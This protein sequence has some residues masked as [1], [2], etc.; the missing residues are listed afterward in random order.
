MVSTG[1]QQQ[2]Q[3]MWDPVLYDTPARGSS[4]GPGLNAPLELKNLEVLKEW[5]DEKTLQPWLSLRVNPGSSAT[6]C[7]AMK[8]ETRDHST[9]GKIVWKVQSPPKLQIVRKIKNTVFES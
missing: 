7:S 9:S 6:H 5:Q 1:H 8:N 3:L 2:A 4:I